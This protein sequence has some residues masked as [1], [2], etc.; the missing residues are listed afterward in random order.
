MTTMRTV[1]RLARRALLT[2]ALLL[3]STAAARASS[4][5][6]QVDQ[7]GDFVL[8]GNT[9]GYDCGPGVPAPVVGTVGACG[10]NTSDTA[11]DVFW[12]AADS[13]S[14]NADTSIPNANARSTSML[15]L[16]A[17]AVITY[18]RLYWSASFA[19][20][21][22]TT[23]I[24]ERPAT[25][26]TFSTTVTADQSFTATSA[27]SITYYQS[28]A[29]VTALVQAHGAGAYRVGGVSA[30]ELLNLNNDTVYAAW[31]MVVFYT[32]A[33]DP[34]R[35]LTIFDGLDLINS[36]G[37][38]VTD[39]L[40]GFVVPNAG[41]DAKLGT[42]AYEGDDQL[43]GDS[44]SWNGV[45]LSDAMNPANNFFN[46][47]RSRLGVAVS[48]TGDLPQLTGGARSMSGIDLD[49]VDLTARVSQGQTSATITAS[50]A[51]DFYLLGLWVTSISTYKPDFSGAI[52]TVSDITS[53]PNGA[54]LPGDTVEYT[55]S[56]TNTG[57]DG[58]T[59]VVLN[60]PIPT[61]LTFV[62][63]SIRIV[64]GANAGTKTD[65]VGDDQGEYIS[66]SRTVRIRLGTGA[67]GTTGGAVP[68]GGSTSVAFRVTINS[69]VNGLIQNQ[70]TITAS[71]ATG[72]PPTDYVSDGNGSGPGAPPTPI[73]VDG[74]ASNA[75]CSGATPYCLTTASPRV[76]VACLSNAN[77][78]GT[79][80]TCDPATHACRACAGDSECT[81]AT[82]ACEASG[83]CGQC[84]A[85]NATSCTGTVSICD[86]PITTCV[87]CVTD[88]NCAAPTPVCNPSSKTCVGCLGNSDCGGA[89]PV[90]DPALRVCRGC[91]GDTECSGGT[92]ACEPSGACGV[93]SAGNAAQCVGATPVCNVSAGTCVRCVANADC[94]GTTPVC[95]GGTHT[96]R[97]CGGDGECGGTTPACQPSGACGVCS[98]TNVSKC[99]GTTPACAIATGTCRGCS[100]DGECGGGTPACE[101]SGACGVCSSTNVS[102]CAGTTPVCNTGSE[103]C[104]GCSGDGE[105]GG[106]TPACQ[107][108]GACG[109]CSSTNASKCGG[110]T[111]VCNTGSGTC[112]TCVSNAQCN[113]ATP[114][115]NPSGGTCR[116]CAGDGDCGG[117]TPACQPNGGCG[118]CSTSNSAMCS[119]STPVCN[120]TSG[121]CVTC[122]TGAQCSGTTPVCNP[123]GG[124]CHGCSADGDCSGA[125]PACQ[126][127][128]ACGVCSTANTS[129]CTGATPVCATATGSC[130]GCTADA[131]CGG[132]TPACQPSGACG[133]CS[134]KNTSACK[135]TTPVCNAGT[136]TCGGCTADAQCGGAT[137]VC[138]PSGACGA[139]TPA[140]TAN[141]PAARP[142]CD[143]SSGAGVC[144]GCRTAADC[145]GVTPVC[146]PTTHTCGP[147]TSDGAPSCPD[148]SR[149]ACQASGSLAGACTE[150][151]PSNA[152]KCAG[153]KPECLPTGLCGCDADPA[154]GGPMSGMICSGPNGVCTPGCGTAPRNDCP[155][156]M[157]CANIVNGTGTCGTSSGCTLDSDC[158]SPLPRCNVATTSGQ[159]VQ[160]LTDADCPAP[161]VCDPTR[162]SCTECTPTKTAA[163]DPNL[164]GAQCLSGGQCGCTDDADCGNATSGRVCNTPSGVCGPGCRGTGGNSCPVSQVCTSTTT[165]IGGCQNPP[166]SDGGADGGGGARGDSGTDGPTARDGSPGD[167]SGGAGADGGG[168]GGANGNGG[169]SATDGGL[170][171]GGGNAGARGGAGGN[172]GN[173]G[174]AADGGKNPDAAFINVNGTV[175]GGGCRCDA[176]SPGDLE[177]LIPILGL[178]A[179]V[180]RR[181]RPRRKPSQDSTH[182][183][184]RSRR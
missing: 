167:G 145:G 17:G 9:L 51:Q 16:P 119:G 40:N 108:S 134:A 84:S 99:A 76:C 53:H 50:T 56:A 58:A 19:G 95:D 107:P 78:G 161:F 182:L 171:G 63:G 7:K 148:P 21:P 98:S 31:A 57:N 164:A 24:L 113:G 168:R 38:S 122:V 125:T 136:G 104:R 33:T 34:Q 66:S 176:A 87:Q 15:I 64:S 29:D 23:A 96:C 88:A 120:A 177:G 47:T 138:Q 42:V 92:P 72:A 10:T 158:T 149:P 116:G 100:G 169:A 55:I 77:C 137:P 102:K 173:G 183:A 141:C 44:L 166:P 115:C 180:T 142:L 112:V 22:D 179:L 67:N 184:G 83:A 174:S 152:G 52:K 130:R 162:N 74:C 144:V 79:T 5:R 160:C 121:T 159:C 41:F 154:C 12:Q 13:L 106:G 69:L 6:Y 14:A 20:P 1:R 46:G 139:C 80:P 175:L 165:A 97:G 103:T 93:C 28:T 86:V 143:T 123:T 30:M 133:V 35:N 157:T 178:L 25:S 70:A 117:S 151:S 32:L 146:S 150:C 49:V 75:D 101:P 71:G 68:V 181:V 129:M 60:D 36:T 94:S 156:G 127:N 11:P 118:I 147:C 109:V 61:G 81:G 111:P 135:G 62:P 153:E 4:L 155:T 8:L 91:S 132:T 73:V 2:A 126:P 82:P 27:T 131:D 172:A 140:N 43:T 85:T 65:A 89:T 37:P 114:V 54:V 124:T 26:D 45:A 110:T 128:G 105:C 59:N 18:A 170:T 3:A 48:N 90:C 163:C 39:T